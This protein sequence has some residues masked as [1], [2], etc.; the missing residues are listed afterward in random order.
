MPSH[1]FNSLN[2]VLGAIEHQENW[3]S[4]R[5]FQKL[6][7]CWNEV[8]GLAVAA[9]TRP[10]EIQRKVLQVATSSPAWAQNLAFERHLILTK[11]NDRLALGLKDIRFSAAQWQMGDRLFKTDSLSLWQ[12]HPS[13]LK[14]PT[15]FTSAA[16]TDPQT[17]FRSWAQQMRSRS[18]H[19]PLCPTCHCPTPEGELVRWSACALCAAKQFR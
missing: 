9:Q 5:Q 7:A 12:S 2:H 13:R 11:L 16:A 6:L 10:V 17:A 3:Q 8:V 14:N 15:P 18:Q 1:R 19:L 4:R